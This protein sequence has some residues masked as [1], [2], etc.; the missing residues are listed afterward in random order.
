MYP[1]HVVAG[2]LLLALIFYAITGGADFGG[3]MWDLLAT[4]QRAKEQ[5]RAIARAI[6][7]I[8]EANH[9]WLIL[10]V[11]ILFT[12]FPWAF[13]G[14]MT[15]LNIPIT[16]M[17]VGVIF[18]GCAFIFRKYDSR[19]EEVQDRWSTMFG[20]ASFFTPMVQ[21]VTLGA[22]A[23]GHIRIE[24]GSVTTGF[25]VAWLTPFA[26]VCGLFA[27]GLCAFLA[28][29][30]L[31][32]DTTGQP[33]VQ[34]DFRLRALLSEFA[35]VPIALVAFF[36]SRTGAPEIFRGLTSNWAFLL[37][38]AT[39]CCVAVA[40]LSL[41]WRRFQIARLAAIGQT[42]LVLLGWSLA[43]YPY[44]IVP[45]V[46]IGNAAAPA[47][48]LRLLMIALVLGTILLLPSLFFLFYIFKGNDTA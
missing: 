25:L 2:F 22:L 1:E 7:P 47:V 3:G 41:W 8:W 34:D 23:T 12:A 11:V 45:D 33:K 6:G 39:I 36:T 21:G 32:I 13:A 17:L 31:T 26:F 14:M 16:M 30:Y 4:G 5:R 38:G 20:A 19:K 44:L 10:V 27:L 43:Q 24:K 48:T 35:L 46:T 37:E 40:L 18:R 15:A 42:T 9:V 28:A 29:T